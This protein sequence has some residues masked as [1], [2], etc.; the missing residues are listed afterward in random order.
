VTT[1]IPF[2]LAT[3]GRE[4]GSPL[5]R[6]DNR[7]LN[8]FAP[9]FGFAYD[10]GGRGDLVIRGGS[11]VFYTIS[12]SNVTFS[13][14]SFN[15]ER[16]LVNSYPNDRLP[17]F[18]DDPTRGVTPDDVLN[19]RVPLPPQS[20][21]VIASNYVMPYTWQSSI[22]FQKQLGPDIGVDADLIYWKGYNEPRSIDYNQFFD[23]ATGY[24]QTIS[25]FGRPDPTFTSIQYMESTGHMDYAALQTGARRRFKDNFQVGLTYTLMFMKNDDT[26]DWGYFP[27]NSFD[28]DAD[29]ARATDFQRNTLR[30]NGMYNLGLGFSVSGA[31]YY[32]SGNYFATLLSGNPTGKSGTNNRLNLGTPIPVRP[33]AQDRFEGPEV[34]EVGPGNE[35]PRSARGGEGL[36]RVDVRLTK[37]FAFGGVRISGIA[38]VFNL[39][40]H[41]NFGAYNGVINTATFG[42]PQQNGAIAYS[43]RSA[44]LAFRVDF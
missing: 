11:G 8:N 31:Y 2:S 18:L 13:Q 15:T 21:R 38:E 33:E 32:G 25:R 30:L 37:E 14:Q 36:R 40:N 44:Q 6:S 10:V 24:T 29:W 42:N 35:A 7:D 41:A 28:P 22:G 1:Q 27:N 43:S 26:T 12:S 19:G 23:P 39:F 20:P 34:I 5:F 16:I 4:A 3:P 9:R 17:G